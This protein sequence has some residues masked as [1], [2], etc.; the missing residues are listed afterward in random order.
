MADADMFS[1]GGK[2]EGNTDK[3]HTRGETSEENVLLLS[4]T[5]ATLSSSNEPTNTKA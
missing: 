5:L 4:D 3:E 2:T 1:A